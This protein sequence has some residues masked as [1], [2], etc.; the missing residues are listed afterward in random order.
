MYV[1]FDPAGGIHVL[2]P[3]DRLSDA[4]LR[5][6]QAM[7]RYAGGSCASHVVILRSAK[8]DD[9]RSDLGWSRLASSAE[10]HVLP[11]DHV[12]LITRHVGE[13]ARVAR[14]A[15]A[16]AREGA[17]MIARGKLRQ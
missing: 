6:S 16:R 12:T 8:L 15:I 17:P 13:L 11:G 14:A 9:A 1:T 3:Q 4:Q 5:Y 2:A 10:I 7:D